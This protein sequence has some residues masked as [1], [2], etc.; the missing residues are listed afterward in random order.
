MTLGNVI[1][2]LISLAGLYFAFAFC[3]AKFYGTDQWPFKA[4][5]LRL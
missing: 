1:A 3:K 5:N 2:I 4:K